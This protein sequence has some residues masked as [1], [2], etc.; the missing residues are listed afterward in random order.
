MRKI[1]KSSLPGQKPEAIPAK[2]SE[3]RSVAMHEHDFMAFL[4][5]NQDPRDWLA[6]VLSRWADSNSFSYNLQGIQQVQRLLR[7]DFSALQS[8]EDSCDL[9]PQKALSPEGHIIERP[10]G[11]ALTFLKRPEQKLRVFLCCHLD[12]VFAPDHPFQRCS[13]IDDNTLGG[14]G[15]ADAKGGLLVMLTALRMFEKSPWAANLGWEILI[16]PDEEI[17]SP[18]SAH[19][20]R[21]AAERNDIGLIFEPC[22]PEGK[23]VSHRKGSG[24]FSTFVRGRAAHAGRDP[25]LGRNAILAAARMIVDL[26]AI[27]NPQRGITVNTGYIEG[28]GPPNVVPDRAFFRTNVRVAD[29]QEQQ[30]FESL[31]TVTQNKLNQMDGISVDTFGGFGRPPK[32]LDSRTL[33]LLQ[34]IAECGRDMGLPLL[35]WKGSG[36]TCDGNNLAAAGLVTVDSLGPRGF[37]IHT[38][39]EYVLLDDIM[40]RARLA[41]LLLMKIAAGIV[42]IPRGNL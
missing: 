2:L 3:E 6:S 14:P 42:E 17:G 24:N 16:N 35:E 12:T 39:D 7:E 30:D 13:L 37:N 18:G 40:E 26:H 15:V 19:L 20:L 8:Q 27:Q 28:G 21:Q 33:Y 31:L 9:P 1:Q 4:E 38:Q 34:K 22:S 29:S 11:K 25:H 41:C 5:T 23:L 32:L 10:L 36:G